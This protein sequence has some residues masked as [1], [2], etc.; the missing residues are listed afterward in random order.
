MPFHRTLTVL[1]L[2]V[3]LFPSTGHAFDGIKLYATPSL[4]AAWLKIRSMEI[5]KEFVS[6]TVDDETVNEDRVVG[7]K[8]FYTGS[9]ITPGISAGLKI[10]SLGL[11]VHFAYTAMNTN[12]GKPGDTKTGGYYKEYM[13]SAEL[14]GAVGEN[15]YQ[16]GKIG[17][18]RI[19]FEMS[20][21]LPVWRFAFVLTT[22]VGGIVVDPGDLEI[23]R[24][25]ATKNGFAGDLGA[26]LEIFPLDFMGI[27]IHG[28][29]GFFAFSGTYEGTY[30]GGGGF[31]GHLTFQL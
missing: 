17:I 20:Y 24:A 2:L 23:G 1:A 28:W 22:R 30:G 31:G 18:K 10:K 19:L 14:R 27:G 13:Y 29:G 7:A 6:F 12:E 4:G 15:E 26:R 16:Q 25:I 9:G 11:G 5:A 21:G 8:S 3:C